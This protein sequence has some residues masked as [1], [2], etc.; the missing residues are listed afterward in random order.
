MTAVEDAEARCQ[1]RAKDFPTSYA[2]TDIFSDYRVITG[3]P[4]SLVWHYTFEENHFTMEDKVNLV[5]FLENLYKIKIRDDE[6]VWATTPL[7]LHGLIQS[8]VSKAQAS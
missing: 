1:Q 6:L 8:H 5:D 4:H 3:W 7:R 2:L